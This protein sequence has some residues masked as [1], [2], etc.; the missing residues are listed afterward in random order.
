MLRTN[1]PNLCLPLQN[2]S[3]FNDLV[4]RVQ[5]RAGHLPGMACFYGHSGY[6]KSWAARQGAH[7]SGAFYIE[8]SDS[9]TRKSLCEQIL[10]EIG[11]GNGAVKGS[12][13]RLVEA[14]NDR[15]AETGDRPLIIDEADFLLKKGLL[16]LV[17]GFHDKSQAPIILL[18]EELLPAKLQANERFHNRMLDWVAALPC[19]IEDAGIIAR[20]KNDG[21][22]I[23]EDLIEAITRACD[24]RV[25]RIMV[26]LQQVVS[27]A[28]QTAKKK[29]NIKDWGDR[30][31]FTGEPPRRRPV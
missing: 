5:S 3:L 28:K 6:G 8:L 31:F 16:D 9:V 24:G 20:A 11:L 23:D 7:R 4:E 15:L 18:G 22:A 19:G 13:V 27:F 25:R 17:R 2:I 30:P 10:N 14:I 1:T 29:V 26:N 12:T 21:I